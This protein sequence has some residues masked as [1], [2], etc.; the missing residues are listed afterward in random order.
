MQPTTQQKQ[1]PN[2]RRPGG[3][4]R[5]NPHQKTYASEN[6]LPRYKPNAL[7][8]PS[9]PQKGIPGADQSVRANSTGQKQ[10]NRNNNSGKKPRH[11][12]GNVSPGLN[13]ANRQTPILQSKEKSAPIFAGSTF[14]ASPAPSALPIPS[15][16]SKAEVDSPSPKVTSSPEQGLSSPSVESD[17]ASP[18]SPTSVPRT[19][20]S[21][22]EFFFRADRAEKARTRRASSSNIDAI[23]TG[24]FPPP[25]DSP[26]ESGTPKPIEPHTARRPQYQKHSTVIGI[27]A[28]ELDGN[29]GQ[30]VGPAFS[31]P[32]H[33][34]IRAARSLQNPVQTTPTML[35]NQDLSS[36]LNSPEVLKRYLF[37]GRLSSDDEQPQQLPTPSKQSSRDHS[38][39]A[40]GYVPQHR[41]PRGVLPVSA[42]TA[43]AQISQSSAPPAH[44]QL[45][46]YRSEQLLAM[47]DGLKRMLKLDSSTQSLPLR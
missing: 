1:T 25:Y 35:R 33:E 39:P 27:S 18:P 29:P 17:E 37:T 32:Y 3:R 9:T 24:P 21:P 46:P 20:E 19:E 44:A 26:R 40:Y 6:D 28:N 15:F 2:H 43:N 14:H 45:T 7:A 22:L 31:T 34:R 13:K 41:L 23:A 4:T 16:L 12:N 42:L 5:N 38:K 30:P 8:N 47:E 10:R 11:K 36:R